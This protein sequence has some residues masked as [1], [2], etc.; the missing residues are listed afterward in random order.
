M[1][2]WTNPTFRLFSLVEKMK[3]E[4]GRIVDQDRAKEKKEKKRMKER[5]KGG[6]EKKICAVRR[7]IIRYASEEEI[8]WKKKINKKDIHKYQELPI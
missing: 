7:T 4:S 8:E 3:S 5:K 6:I 2:R 1:T